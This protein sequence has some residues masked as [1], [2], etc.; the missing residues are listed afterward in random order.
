MT[1]LEPQSVRLDAEDEEDEEDEPSQSPLVWGVRRL[2]YRADAMAGDTSFQTLVRARRA[3][4]LPAGCARGAPLSRRRQVML[5]TGVVICLLGG[6]ALFAT[7]NTLRVN[8]FEDGSYGVR[9]RARARARCAAVA[10]CALGSAY[11]RAALPGSPVYACVPSAA[12]LRAAP[13]RVV[14]RTPQESVWLAWSLFVDPASLPEA[15]GALL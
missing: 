5:A 14:A 8:E 7:D 2:L 9:A 11:W 6:R 12:S 10:L 15:D 13:G 4:G 3:R 1:A